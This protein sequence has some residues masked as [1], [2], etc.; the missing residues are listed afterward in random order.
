[1]NNRHQLNLFSFLTC[2]SPFGFEETESQKIHR[3]LNCL[4]QTLSRRSASINF[5]FCSGHG[6]FEWNLSHA[7]A[8]GRD[9]FV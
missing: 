1:M 2:P 6:L 8:H 4:C 3:L 7:H 5:C 9:P